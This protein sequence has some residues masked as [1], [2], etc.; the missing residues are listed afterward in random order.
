M[1]KT[2]YVEQILHNYQ[3]AGTGIAFTS[4]K[5][6]ADHLRAIKSEQ[7]NVRGFSAEELWIVYE[8]SN[9]VV[10]INFQETELL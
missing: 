8:I 4:K 6:A 3:L 10:Q 9:T 1:S 5:K 2:I 7:R